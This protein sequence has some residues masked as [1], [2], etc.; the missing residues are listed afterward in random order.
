MDQQKIG[1]FI[2]QC[3]KKQNLTQSQLAEK[4]NITDRA[5]SK[6]E[7]GRAM[8]DSSIMLE[9]CN[10][11]K[12]N[13]NDLLSGEIIAMNE[14]DKKHEELLLEMVKQKEKNDKRFLQLEIL[15]GVLSIIILLSFTF[16]ASFLEMEDWLRVILIVSGF[17]FAIFGLMIA[18]VIE[19]KAGYYQCEKCGHRYVPKFSNVLMAMHVNRTR[20]MKCPVCKKRSWQRK[21]ISKQK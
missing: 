13:V 11:L 3:R 17:V 15:I 8:P 18:L 21:V 10:I 6:W 4:L 2:A 14:Y 16:A 5:V 12:I 19:Q 20:Y 9:L 7:T 1:S